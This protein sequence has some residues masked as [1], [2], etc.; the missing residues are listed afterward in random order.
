MTNLKLCCCCCQIKQGRCHAEVA[1]CIKLRAG[2]S[3]SWRYLLFMVVFLQIEVDP[4]CL[5][6]QSAWAGSV[7]S[8]TLI[9][10]YYLANAGIWDSLLVTYP[11][12]CKAAGW[13]SSFFSIWRT[14]KTYSSSEVSVVSDSCVS[15]TAGANLSMFLEEYTAKS[16]TWS[17]TGCKKH[18][19]FQL[20]VQAQ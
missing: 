14:N 8:L 17:Y 10:Q 5:E 12:Y 6:M 7:A 15:T 18:C 11:K 20:D 16:L 19:A 2:Q 9:P 13:F 4:D 3:A 1:G